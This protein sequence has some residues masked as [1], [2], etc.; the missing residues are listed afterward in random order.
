MWSPTSWCI[1]SVGVVATTGNTYPFAQCVKCLR[2]F[3]QLGKAKCVLGTAPWHYAERNKCLC[4]LFYDLKEVINNGQGGVRCTW[5]L[6]V[7]FA[8]FCWCEGDCDMACIYLSLAL[9]N[10]LAQPLSVF[11][12]FSLFPVLI[13]F[14]L[15]IYFLNM[16]SAVCMIQLKWIAVQLMHGDSSVR[17]SRTVGH[18][19]GDFMSH[20]LSSKWSSSHFLCGFF[21][22]R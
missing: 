9:L 15:D 12:F 3:A 11:Y 22:T 17:H 1:A 8:Y 2:P 6:H 16:V 19:R 4:N 21:S 13:R 10:F 5:A 18:F 7:L 14:W 20:G